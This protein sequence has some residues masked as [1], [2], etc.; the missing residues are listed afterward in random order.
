MAVYKNK[1]AIQGEGSTSVIDRHTQRGEAI[2]A[3]LFAGG[4]QM[5][6][7]EGSYFVA[8]N[9]TWETAIAGGI[10]ATFSDIVGLLAI[11]N[12]A[13]TGGKRIFLDYIRLI[14]TVIPASGTNQHFGITVDNALTR[15]T[16]GGTA[17]TP[18]NLNLGSDQETIAAVN[19]GVLT[20][21]AISSKGI[22]AGR[23]QARTTVGVVGD[24][25]EFKF[26]SLSIPAQ[27]PAK[28]TTSD[29]IVMHCAPVVLNGQE[30]MV[31]HHWAASNATTGP[32]YEIEMGWSER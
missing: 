3:P 32:S 12:T 5:L 15:F 21:A 2:T 1:P 4:A 27:G 23:M 6:T 20:I 16:S 14:M 25:Y 17:L 26:G 22:R 9:A 7:D 19:F 10:T 11:R 29:H 31:L 8:T 24:V 13:A 18:K 28:A 30:V